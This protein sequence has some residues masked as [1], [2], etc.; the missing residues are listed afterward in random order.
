MSASATQLR[1]TLAQTVARAA[2]CEGE[3]ATPVPHL[4]LFRREEVTQPCACLI[5]PSV[6]LVV[7]G[8]KQVLVGDVAYPY[9]VDHFL[10]TSLDLPAT[11][12]VIDASQA[13]PCL[14]LV[15]KLDLQVIAELIAHGG[16]TP[17]A[18]RNSERGLSL[19]SVTLPL[20]EAFKRLVDL[21]DEPEAI[22]VLSPLIQ[23]EIL[24]RLLNSD[25]GARLW[26]I[27]SSGSQSQRIARAIDW[28][29]LNFAQPLRVPELAERVQMSA[30]SL[31]HHFRQ[32]TAMSPLQYQ[33]WLRLHEARRLMVNEHLDA[34]SAAFRVG[35][36]SPSQF[37]REYSRLFGSPPRRDVDTLLQRHVAPQ[38]SPVPA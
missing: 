26:Q 30:S 13:Q 27:A 19:G 12:Q 10:V 35:Y 3:V 25:Q 20:L 14:G 21:L 15:L 4:L 9:D 32:L 29:K 11:S 1:A 5:E 23:R 8:T 18:E 2:T 7:Q 6:V 24:F 28:L 38:R 16:I 17:P 33:K 37:S 31:H 22:P 36:E 34:A